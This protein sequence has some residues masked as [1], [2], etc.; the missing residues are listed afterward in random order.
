MPDMSDEP[1]ILKYTEALKEATEQAM[2]ADP[3]VFVVGL[4]VSYKNG[5]DGTTAGLKALYPERVLDVP[6]SED[7]F[8]GMAVGA[9]I[10]GLRPIV[11]HG[12]VEFALFAADQIFTQ[13]AKWNYMFGGGHPVPIVFRINIGRQWGNGP[14]HTQALYGLFGSA[15]GLKVVIPSSPYMAKGLL[16]AAIRDNNPVV[17]L[18][19]R[20]NFQLKE[21]VPKEPYVLPLDRAHIVHEGADITVV[22][23]GDGLIAAREALELVGDDVDIDMIDLVSINPIDHDTVI[24][25]V[26]KTGRLITVDTTNAAFSI[27]SEVIARVLR[28]QDMVLKAPVASLS[29]PNVPCPTSTALTERY[30]PTKV[31][32]ANA[33]LAM[34]GKAPIDMPLSFEELHMAPTHTIL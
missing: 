1:R 34:L 33:I 4:G 5:A 23:Y 2:A 24:A 15:L 8:T 3:K 32:V 26:R 30:Y 21:A 10:H 31:D 9:A 17:L 14:Q 12:R 11:H 25:S 22:S 16:A 29:C 6:V 19:P 20:W 7:A 13:A 18:E 27:G 28:D